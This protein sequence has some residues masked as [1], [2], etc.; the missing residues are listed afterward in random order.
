MLDLLTTDAAAANQLQDMR[1]RLESFH[2]I[3]LCNHILFIFVSG[4]SLNSKKQCE[5]SFLAGSS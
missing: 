3:Q 4:A 2:N 1:V 5:S